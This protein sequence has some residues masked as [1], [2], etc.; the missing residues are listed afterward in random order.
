MFKANDY[1]VK[2]TG[3][4]YP[5][6]Q[7]STGEPL[8]KVLDKIQQSILNVSSDSNLDVEVEDYG[9][10]Y[11]SCAASLI[12]LKFKYS[13][14]KTGGGVL[15]GWDLTES[16][17][18]LPAGYSLYSVTVDTIGS[19]KSIN[20][21]SSQSSGFSIPLVDLPAISTIK[22]TLNSP[23]GLVNLDYVVN[24]NSAVLGVFYPYFDVKTPG[25]GRVPKN[26]N[27]LLSAI[28]SNV[29][30]NKAKLTTIQLGDIITQIQQLRLE[31]QKI[32]IVDEFEDSFDYSISGSLEK[33]TLQTIIDDISLRLNSLENRMTQNEQSINAIKA[34]L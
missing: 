8:D 20:S 10:T 19:N 18:A 3:P 23:C 12:G 24:I 9:L 28:S 31:I 34:Q 15:Y 14:E 17:A 2:Y 16:I 25:T 11:S 22:L 4:N 1:S 6:L 29:L 5:G 26:L 27:E 32:P 7:I 13:V 21:S 30:E 33:R